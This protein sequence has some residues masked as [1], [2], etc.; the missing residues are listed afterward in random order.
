MITCVERAKWDCVIYF[1]TYWEWIDHGRF[2]CEKCG[3]ANVLNFPPLV[4][5]HFLLPN[6]SLPLYLSAQ[7][8]AFW[9]LFLFSFFSR[10]G[11][12]FSRI[13]ERL[14]D[15]ADHGALFLLFV[16]FLFLAHFFAHFSQTLAC[17]LLTVIDWLAARCSQ[18]SATICWLAALTATG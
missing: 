17:V 14:V 3:L 1:D 4:K 6:L 2:L 16:S 11:P 7:F 12:V 5:H 8:D 15:C 10:A 13:A 18:P 9:C